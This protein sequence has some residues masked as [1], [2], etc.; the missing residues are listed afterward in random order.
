MRKRLL[1]PRVHNR[2]MLLLLL[3]QQLL[4]LCKRHFLACTA[5]HCTSASRGVWLLPTNLPNHQAH[6]HPPPPA[7]RLTTAD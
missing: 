1:S 6:T 3:G 4:P 5:V 7:P 2:A